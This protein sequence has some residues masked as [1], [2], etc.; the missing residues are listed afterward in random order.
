MVVKCRIQTFI[1]WM[2]YFTVFSNLGPSET[3]TKSPRKI[4][5]VFWWI[6]FGEISPFSFSLQSSNTFHLDLRL[7]LLLRVSVTT[8]L[9]SYL[10]CL[11]KMLSPSINLCASGCLCS[12]SCDSVTVNDRS[13]HALTRAW[14][15]PWGGESLAS[16]SQNE[17]P[18]GI[19][20]QEA[21]SPV[22]Y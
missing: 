16:S 15:P 3:R 17:P 20:Y 8:F 5:S 6:L 13:R 11:I 1:I 21:M 18:R 10:K 2:M 12:M 7:L 4:S 9:D 22:S 14:S 19:S